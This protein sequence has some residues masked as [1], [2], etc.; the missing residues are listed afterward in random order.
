[1]DTPKYTQSLESD[2]KAW[3]KFI[4]DMVCHEAILP[5]D[6][7]YDDVCAPGCCRKNPQ[8]GTIRAISANFFALCSV[9]VTKSFLVLAEGLGLGSILMKPFIVAW[10]RDKPFKQAVCSP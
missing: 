5:K 7:D 10:T 6:V 1:M 3:T 2:I 9:D 8:Y 4:E